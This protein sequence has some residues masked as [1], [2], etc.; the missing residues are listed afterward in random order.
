ML[1]NWQSHLPAVLSLALAV[2]FFAPEPS[3][4]IVALVI[5]LWFV[6]LI[7]IKGFRGLPVSWDVFAMMSAAGAAFIWSMGWL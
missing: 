1:K 3:T 7:G 4:K 2:S 5:L 6:P